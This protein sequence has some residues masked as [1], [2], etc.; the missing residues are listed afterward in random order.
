ME[1][2]IETIW[3]KGFLKEEDLTAPRINNLHQKKSLLLIEK[4]KRTYKI[5]N[6]S[7]IPLAIL[8]VV[9]FSV[10]GHIITGLYVMILMIAMFVL[11]KKKLASLDKI[12][13]ETTSYDY[14]LKYREMFFQLKRFNIFLLG[15]GLPIAGIIGYYLFFRNSPLLSDFLQLEVIYIIGILL[16]VS[17]L[18]SALGIMA[19]LLSLKLIYGRFIQKLEEM[20]ADME[21]LRK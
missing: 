20:I 7:I 10:A 2:S 18:L 6:K 11:N 15:L 17:L 13:I 4:L 9:G 19:Y 8:S 16:S 5:D 12:S 1:N 21:E 3:T 14:L